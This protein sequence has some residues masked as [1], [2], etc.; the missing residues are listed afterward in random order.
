M[1]Y[2]RNLHSDSNTPKENDVSSKGKR[3]ASLNAEFGA[4]FTNIGMSVEHL[5]N[6]L[7]AVQP[8]FCSR[9]ILG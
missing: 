1:N 2:P 4:A 8:L 7:N 5:E 9:D 6:A 3:T